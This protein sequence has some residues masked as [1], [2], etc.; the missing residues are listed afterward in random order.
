[1]PYLIKIKTQSRALQDL[2]RG[3]GI[4]HSAGIEH[5]LSGGERLG[6]DDHQR[7]LGSQAVEGAGH[8]HGIH[9]GQKAQVAAVRLT[10]CLLLGPASSPVHAQAGAMTP[11][12]CLCR[13]HVGD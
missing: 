3:F 8:I 2:P 7:G 9:V 11:G 6:D 10:C 1:M 13:V 5:G 12:E 4:P